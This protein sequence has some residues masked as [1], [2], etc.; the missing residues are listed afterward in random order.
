MAGNIKGITIEIDGNV[1][2]LQKALNN[3]SKSVRDTQKELRDVNRLLKFDPKN[4][5]LLKQKQDLLNRAVEDAQKKLDTEKAALEAL[6]K[7][8]QTDQVKAKMEKLKVEIQKDT[9][10]LYKAEKAFKDFGDAGKQHVQEVA[11]EVQETGKKISEVGGKIKGVGDSLTKNVTAPIMALGGASLAAFS[12]VDA[13]YDTVIQKTGATG[14]AAQEMYDIVDQLA[15]SIPTDFA[16]AG[17]AVGE[18]STRFGLTGDALEDLSSK[19]IKF[20][21]L[22]GTDVTSAV[23]ST[24]K[25]LEAFG[26]GAEDAG[27]YLDVLNKAAQD[28]GISVDTLTGLTVN[29]ATALSEMGL[30]LE[31]STVLM[32]QLE[33]SGVPVETA[34]GGLSKALK[35]ATDEGVPFDDA[36]SDLQKTIADSESDTEGLAAAYD[37]FGKSGDKIFKAVKDGSI[38]FDEL[39]SAAVDSTDSVASTFEETLDPIDQ[40]KTTLNELKLTGAELGATIGEVLQPILEQVSDVI[41]NLREKWEA[42][43]PEQQNMIV[44][45]A[46]IIAVVGPVI[47]I[48]GSIVTGIGGLITA[49]GT[50]AGVL[51]MAASTVGIVIVAITAIV[52]AIV[53][54]IT[55]WDQVKAKV[56]EVWTAIVT[57]VS[58]LKEDLSAKWNEIKQNVT[59][60]IETMKNEALQKITDLKDGFK[61]KIDDIKG[62]FK[63]L[64]LKFPKIEMPDLPHFKLEGEFSLNPPSVPHLEVEWF[65]KAMN[66]PYLFTTP[67]MFAAGEAGAEVMYGKESLMR[68]IAQ[69]TAANNDALIDGM[70]IAMTEALRQADIKVEI[71]DREFG[72]ILREAR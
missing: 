29:N 59:D 51:G 23:D 68:D 53:L 55:H 54:L 5:E 52:A 42:L 7:A 21:E 43:S 47:A 58:N 46:G 8:D 61:K 26:L 66:N 25:A 31:D 57:Y 45:I 38:N 48:I 32:A 14:D 60:K 49:I 19:Y 3:A 11:K 35:K 16:T 2:P 71:N 44:Q 30:S 13:G 34:I 64:I 37:L 69:A 41:Q 63:N 24:Q 28:S 70:Y 36:L 4:V 50:V 1:T 33:K 27:T 39:G 22:N 15:T 10:E 65:A 6:G 72:R 9:E 62:F 67:T 18:V 17:E 56:E 40:W 20:A 12:E